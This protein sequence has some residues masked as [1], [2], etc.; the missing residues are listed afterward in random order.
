MSI[1]NQH[2]RM[3]E[4]L[5]FAAVEPLDEQTLAVRLPEGAD[6]PGII[7]ELVRTYEDRGVQRRRTSRFCWRST[8]R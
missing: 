4:A 1:D 7:E 5:L 3:A 2:L 8:A 6:V